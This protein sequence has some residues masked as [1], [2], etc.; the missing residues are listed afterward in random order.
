MNSWYCHFKVTLALQKQWHHLKEVRGMTIHFVLLGDMAMTR[1]SLG[2]NRLARCGILEEYFSATNVWSLESLLPPSTCIYFNF[3]WVKRLCSY[4]KI[5]YNSKSFDGKMI[6]IGTLTYDTSIFFFKNVLLDPSHH[7]E[8][9]HRV[10]TLE[11]WHVAQFYNAVYDATNIAYKKYI[12]SRC[13][14]FLKQ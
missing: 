9:I 6:I 12:W 3:F 1:F 11:R 10:K 7:E 14:I 4:F 2:R 5:C 8:Q 13:S